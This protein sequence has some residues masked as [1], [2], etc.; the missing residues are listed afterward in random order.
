MAALPSEMGQRVPIQ[1]GN[2]MGS[3]LPR[4]APL[5]KSSFAPCDLHK[6]NLQRPI[7]RITH[8]MAVQRAVDLIGARIQYPPTLGEL[9]TLAG[10]SRTYF[11]LVF[12]EITGKTL[13]EYIL[14]ARMDKA[15]E[16]LRDINLKIKE[17]AR[18]VGFTDP[19]HFSRTF[20]KEM[21]KTPTDWRTENITIERQS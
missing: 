4:K 9:A 12:R 3:P 6:A 21:G 5:A 2:L 20:K 1:R 13:R 16:L 8:R 19:N 15:K 7:T 17:I 14:K 11:S 10:L 18:Q